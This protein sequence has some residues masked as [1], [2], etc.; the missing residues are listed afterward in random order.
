[1][2]APLFTLKLKQ[3]ILPRRVTLGK[4]DGVNPNLACATSAGK[5]FIHN[6]FSGSQMSEGK[7]SRLVTSDN[8][9]PDLYYLNIGQQISAMGAG[10]LGADD[11]DTL[12]VGSQT[13]FLAYDVHNNSDL[14]YRECPDGVN[15]IAH[16]Y[17]ADCD[18]PLVFTGGNCSISGF[19]EDGDD[20]FWTVTGDNVCSLALLDYNQDNIN[21]LVVGSEDYEIRVFHSDEMIA[22]ITET[23]SVTCLAAMNGSKFGYALANGTVGVYDRN[24]R[25]WRIKSKNQAVSIF[26]YDLNGDGVPELIT[27]WSSGKLDARSSHNGEVVFKDNFGSAVAGIVEGDYRRDGTKQLIT[28]SVDGEVRGYSPANKDSSHNLM[29]NDA[30]QDLVRELA[31]RK[32]NLLLELKN[33]SENTKAGKEVGGLKLSATTDVDGQHMGIIPANTQL[34]TSLQVTTETDSM[35]SHVQL[36]I[37]TTNTT[38]IKAVM[39]FAEGIFNGESHVVHP[40]SSGIT[41]ALSVPIFPPKDVPIDLHVKT[42]VGHKNSSQ[43]HVFELSRQL[44]RFTLYI[45]APTNTAKPKSFVSFPVNERINRVVMWINQNFLL[46]E[47]VC[48]ISADTELDLKLMALRTGCPIF[49]HMVPGTITIHCEDI[50]LVGDIVQA[51]AASLNIENMTSTANFPDFI[52]KLKEVLVKVD[53][54]HNVRQKLTAE[55][56]DHSNLIRSLVVRAEDARL[57]NDMNSM[58]QSYLKLYDLNRDLVNG[59]NI[60]CNNHSELLACL[61][62]V[63]QGIQKAGRLRVGKP[64]TQVV[65][66]CRSAIKQGDVEKLFKI[67]ECGGV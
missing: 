57:M 58:K 19:S 56:A 25:F 14:F 64:K 54:Y 51:L 39:I 53:E 36:L 34:Q 5:V 4:F 8:L 17:I 1:M 43:Y 27:G 24:S 42:F 40:P 48:A 63:N 3:K 49:L 9:V 31:Q 11:K 26:S 33:Y 16:G 38:V 46:D 52:E 41:S 12:F 22:E 59:Y 2:L 13:H 50:D 30:E 65:T 32:N 45:Q 61:K 66:A 15:T 37:N 23:E 67:I 35:P 29:D 18:V 6:P 20:K 28:C 44:P 47:E 62:I 7:S 21:E 10:C 55:M 60:R